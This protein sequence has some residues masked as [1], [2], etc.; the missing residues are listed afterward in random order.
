MEAVYETPLPETPYPLTKGKRWQYASN[1]ALTI[2]GEELPGWLQGEEEVV[3]FEEVKSE[4]GVSYFCA[5][6]RYS[7]EDEVTRNETKITVIATGH[8][9][10]SSDAGVVKEESSMQTFV[11]DILVEEET[12]KLL[13][14]T[15]EEA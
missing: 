15:F 14:R 8:S 13:L 2:D 6:V 10:I 12:R 5:K 9:W 4:E 1:Y 3:G 11:D 7:L